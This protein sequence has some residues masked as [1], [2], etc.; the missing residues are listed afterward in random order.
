MKTLREQFEENYTAIRIPADNKDGFRIKYVYYAPWYLWDLPK[1]TLKKTKRFFMSLS[2]ASLLL[3]L[4]TGVQPCVANSFG[5]VETAGVFA[6]CAHVFELFSMFQFLLAKYRTSR[7]T[8][9]H[10]DRTLLPAS[11]LRG[12]CHMISAAGSVLCATKNT[13]EPLALP[14]A[15]GYL[16]CACMAFCIF[17]GYRKIPVRT[18]TNEMLNHLEA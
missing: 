15:A 6:L 12:S 5:M 7:M 14:V 11:F 3:F 8:Y 17:D 10:V 13:F 16:V 1:G 4:L 2:L 9:I 18:E